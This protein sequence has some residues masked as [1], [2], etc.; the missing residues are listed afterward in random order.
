MGALFDLVLNIVDRA[1]HLTFP[2]PSRAANFI[3]DEGA[4]AIA[5]ALESNTTLTSLDL[6]SGCPF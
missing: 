2:F 3:G 6:D 4:R 5:A 1:L